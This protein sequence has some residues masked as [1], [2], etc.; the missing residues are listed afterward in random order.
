M[1]TTPFERQLLKLGIPKDAHGFVRVWIEKGP[2]R[3]HHYQ[4]AAYYFNSLSPEARAWIRTKAAE[5]PGRSREEN[6]S[7]VVSKWAVLHRR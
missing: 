7:A 5:T 1:K 4:G 3:D 6:L 2:T